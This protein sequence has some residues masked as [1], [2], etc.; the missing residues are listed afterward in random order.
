MAES[1]NPAGYEKQKLYQSSNTPSQ[2]VTTHAEML[3]VA[4]F[5]TP[6]IFVVD[7]DEKTGGEDVLYYWSGIEVRRFASAVELV[8]IK[9]ASIVAA[10]RSESSRIASAGYQL[11]TGLDRTQTGLDVV[12]ASASKDAA[13]AS[14]VEAKEVVLERDPI[15]VATYEEA[16]PL[17]TGDVFKRINVLEDNTEW[18][19]GDKTFYTYDPEL[20]VAFM[21]WV[22]NYDEQ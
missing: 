2:R 18:G 13:A 4:E 1:R 14:A 11:Q 21:G 15:T 12:A 17:F 22:F 19:E 9:E 20:G 7:N 5:K 16:V 10:E 8:E 6:M 3:K